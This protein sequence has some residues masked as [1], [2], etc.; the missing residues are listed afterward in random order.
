[1]SLIL[2]DANGL[3]KQMI[4]ARLQVQFEN[5]VYELQIIHTI[6]FTVVEIIRINLP[7]RVR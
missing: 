1:V 3:A 6:F 5:N 4:V 2:S 7:N